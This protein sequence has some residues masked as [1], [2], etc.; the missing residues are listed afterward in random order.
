MDSNIKHGMQFY[1]QILNGTKLQIKTLLCALDCKTDKL[2]GVC[3]CCCGFQNCPH[4]KCW[5]EFNYSHLQYCVPAELK[6]CNQDACHE[7]CPT[8]I[9]IWFANF[10]SK[11]VEFVPLW[12][13]YECYFLQCLNAKTVQKLKIT[14]FKL[15]LAFTEFLAVLICFWIENTKVCKLNFVNLMHPFEI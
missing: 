15:S 4:A 13:F 12:H 8:Q 10:N 3:F 7:S 6:L 2:N 11:N 14:I 5:L 1:F 9:A